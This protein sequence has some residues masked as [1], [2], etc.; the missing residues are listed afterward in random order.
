MK[1]PSCGYV[2]FQISDECVS[3]GQPLPPDEGGASSDEFRREVRRKR[4]DQLGFAFP[5]AKTSAEATPAHADEAHASTLPTAELAPA[6]DSDPYDSGTQWS[7]EPSTP[8]NTWIEVYRLASGFGRRASAMLVDT[9]FF[10]ALAGLLLAIVGIPT[11]G[12]WLRPAY[13]P[14]Y[15]FL[16]VL[17]GFYFT[18]FH[19]VLGQT[20][21]KLLLRIRVVDSRGGGLLS[22]WDSFVRWIGYFLSALPLGLGFFWSLLDNDDRAFHDKWAHS[23]V[24]LVDS[25][26]TTDPVSA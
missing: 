13:I 4:R 3:C 22:A 23:V 17:H 10:A 15:L 20:P 14:I 26:V 11:D 8:D 5:G 21:G 12:A 6:P 9:V 7:D 2:S 1:C 25:A 19:A 18:F 24:V 16:L